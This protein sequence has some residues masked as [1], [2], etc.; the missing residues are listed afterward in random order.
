MEI[1][2][3]PNLLTERKKPQRCFLIAAHLAS[4]LTG[5]SARARV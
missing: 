3:Y 2:V 1:R 5:K 4:T